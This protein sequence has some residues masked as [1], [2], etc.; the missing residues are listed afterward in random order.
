MPGRHGR[1]VVLAVKVA[2]TGVGALY[3]ATGSV[4]VVMLGCGFAVCLVVALGMAA[5]DTN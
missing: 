4:V 2:F 5:S 3:A 1:S